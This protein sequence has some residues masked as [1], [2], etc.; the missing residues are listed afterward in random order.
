MR[1]MVVGGAGYIGSVTVEQLQKAGHEVVVFDSLI[2]GHRGAILENTPFVHGDMANPEDLQSAFERYPVDAVM[3]FA[4]LSLVGESV[5][6]PA[7]YFTN[8]VANGLKLLEAMG[9]HGVKKLVF[10]STAAVYGEP[11]GWPIHEDFAL[12]PT[13]PYGE[14]KL[15]FEKVLKWYAQAYGLRYAALRYFNAAGATERVGEDHDPETHLIPLV[16]QV[17]RGKREHISVFGDDYATKD[18]TCVRDYIHV[19]DLADAHLRALSVLDT[20]SATFNLG[21]GKGFSV[22]EVIEAA[23]HVTGHPIPTVMAPRR[24]G[25]PAVLVA[26][27][28]RIRQALG[29]VPKYPDLE[30][31]IGDA[32]KWHQRHPEGYSHPAAH[33]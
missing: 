9:N 13:N 1:V 10:S 11:E 25:D 19:V 31:I 28:E 23:R 24:A 7:K 29:W 12:N 26:S 21:N 18:G 16:L 2:K 27:S 22:K 17:A 4:A 33:V 32:W 14:S 15:A 20:G 3:H 8:N 5:T 30:S 6:Q